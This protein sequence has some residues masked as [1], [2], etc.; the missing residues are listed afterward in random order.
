[1]SLSNRS[2]RTYSKPD[3]KRIA[4][5]LLT[6][7]VAVSL[8][9]PM[10]PAFAQI[11]EIVVTA[12]KR[13]ESIMKVPVVASVLT[14]AQI[15]QYSQGNLQDFVNRVPGLD[16]GNSVMSIGTQVSLRGIG[17]SVLNTTMDQSVALN[18]DGMQMTQG[19]AYSV[20]MFDI[21]RIEVLK[22]PHA[23]FYGKAAP[24]GVIA[25]Q[26]AL[27]SDELEVI[28][29]YGHEFE[30]KEHRTDFI[31]SGPVTDTLG[32]RLAARYQDGDGWMKNKAVAA[33]GTGAVTPTE[34]NFAPY[35]DWMV[36]GTAVWEPNDRFRSVLRINS[37]RSESPY[38]GGM[39]QMAS[40]PDGVRAPM[41]I[42]FM[43]GTEDC[44]FDDTIHNVWYDPEVW[45]LLRNSGV[46]FRDSRQKFGSLNIDYSLTPSLTLSSV[47][48]YY[49]LDQ[50]SM[51]NAVMTSH[52]APPIGVD[53][54]FTHEDFTQELRLTSD[55]ADSP[56]D[57]MTGLFYQKGEMAYYNK[58]LGNQA[59]GLPVYLNK[60]YQTIDVEAKSVFGQVI[61]NATPNL[62]IAGGVRWTDEERHHKVYV[63]ALASNT[64]HDP[65]P[66]ELGNPKLRATNWSPELTVTW[67]PS[68]EWTFFGS[69]KRAYKSGSFDSVSIPAPGEDVSFGDEKVSGGELGFKSLLLDRRLSFEAAAYYYDYDDMQVGATVNTPQGEIIIR[70]L[71]A[72]SSEIYGAEFNLTY[73]PASV[74][75]LVLTA[76]ANYNIAEF[77]KFENAQ[78]W[79]G[80]LQNEGCNLLWDE[81]TQ[82][83]TAQDLSGRKQ[84]RAPEWTGFVGADYT[85]P[86]A[87]TGFEL[88]LGWYSS[89]SDKYLTNVL[90][91][92]DMWQDSYIIH[93]A[94]ITL[95]EP[96]RGWSVSLVG[97][98]LENKL[99]A[100]NCQNSN[101]ANGTIFGGQTT[102]GTVRGPAG[103]DDLSCDVVSRRS[104]WLRFEVNLANWF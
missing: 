101:F 31:L 90:S 92:S 49:D 34:R 91:R 85:I 63:E 69:L 83:F 5:T 8:S 76:A 16:L 72:A 39:A 52:A 51:I 81:S 50:R 61:W 64:L 23:L 93:N 74:E 55:F 7:A 79:G 71:N 3:N 22:G 62:E 87:T 18:V 32:L 103:I 44:K 54:D 4:K 60:G 24:A 15:E 26:S 38:D 27:P 78:C 43:G 97:N 19:L 36:R 77:N 102:G 94:S 14:G 84:L 13:E 30:A 68:D 58:L 100:G 28:L 45:P 82:A 70:T 95:R 65:I 33:P 37:S 41:G 35:T 2:G 9:A 40:C 10:I 11:E 21:E 17:N 1:M 48:G 56:F 104:V 98:N 80:Q 25:I 96:N 47:T 67:T 66:W 59:Y 46:P 57:F 29:R 73:H 20:A 42:P 53:P 12:R 88:D 99:V 75:G 89:F 86:L 6:T